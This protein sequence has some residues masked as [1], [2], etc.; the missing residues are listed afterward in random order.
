[1]SFDK[2]DAN[3]S[4]KNMKGRCEITQREKKATGMLKLKKP[5]SEQKI[6]WLN[7]CSNQVKLKMPEQPPT[8]STSSDTDFSKM[9]VNELKSELKQRNPELIKQLEEIYKQE[10]QQSANS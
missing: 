9:T 3:G 2:K 8:Q 5:E 6:I 10:H 4:L 7:I 1:M